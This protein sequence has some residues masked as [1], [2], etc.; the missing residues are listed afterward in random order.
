MDFNTMTD[1]Q[2]INLIMDGD[3]SISKE[4]LYLALNGRY[5]I[6]ADREQTINMARQ[7][8]KENKTLRCVYIDGE[9]C[10]GEDSAE[11]SLEV[12]IE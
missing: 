4:S 1:E 9:S 5:G 6:I 10:D 3:N 2:I 12:W 11:D 7:A 8:L